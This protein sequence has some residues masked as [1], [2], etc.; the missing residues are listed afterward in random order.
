MKRLCARPSHVLLIPLIALLASGCDLV[1][2]YVSGT[3]EDRLV[4]AAVERWA[5]PGSPFFDGAS[6]RDTVASVN[7]TGARAW[8]VGVLPPSG[9]V[10]VVWSFEVVRAEVYAVMPGEAFARWLGERARELGMRT[11]LPPEVAQALRDGD[12]RA[13]GDLEVRY[14]TADRTGRNTEVRVAYLAPG[15]AGARPRW[16]IQPVSRSSNVLLEALQTVVEDM[17]YRDDRVLSC[18]GS[19]TPRGIARAIQLACVGEVWQQEF[20]EDR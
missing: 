14:G 6:G 1:D 15:E 16:R 9:G 10:P 8:E 18:M 20:A 2:R 19:G 3:P 4:D 12:I 11:F 17:V 7:P 5:S 13:V